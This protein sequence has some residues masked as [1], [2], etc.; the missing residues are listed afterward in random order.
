MAWRFYDVYLLLVIVEGD[1]RVLLRWRE[2]S[3]V[4]ICCSCLCGMSRLVLPGYWMLQAVHLLL[5]HDDCLAAGMSGL[6]GVMSQRLAAIPANRIQ[7]YNQ[8]HIPQCPNAVQMLG[9]R[10]RRWTSIKTA[11]AT[12]SGSNYCKQKTF[13]QTFL[14]SNQ[15]T[16]D[17]DPNL[18]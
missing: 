5:M 6:S 4:C 12:V 17:V 14:S 8:H 2:V 11:L 13:N 16:L 18:F 1:S 9:Q 7:N 15:Q 3:M 10:R